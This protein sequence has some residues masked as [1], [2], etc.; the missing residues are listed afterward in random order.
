MTRRRTKIFLVF[1]FGVVPALLL[2]RG[3][4]EFPQDIG[5]AES[6]DPVASGGTAESRSIGI[7][8]PVPDIYPSDLRDLMAFDSQ[9]HG[10]VLRGPGDETK[11]HAADAAVALKTREAQEKPQMGTVE[12]VVAAETQ[13]AQDKPEIDTVEEAAVLEPQVVKQDTEAP[14]PGA[15]Q[16]ILAKETQV[17]DTLTDTEGTGGQRDKPIEKTPE[18]AAIVDARHCIELNYHRLMRGRVSYRQIWNGHGFVTQKVC[19]VD[20][21]NGISS[22]WSFEQG[23][24][25]ITEVQSDSEALK[26]GVADAA[27]PRR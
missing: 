16:E 6:S 27:E 7:D 23:S 14:V 1:V 10:V 3:H 4:W 25:L 11:A 2:V 8:W 18:G 15:R 5:K 22:V 20:E 9:H 13:E 21:G 12:T 24:A 19:L 26:D 17:K